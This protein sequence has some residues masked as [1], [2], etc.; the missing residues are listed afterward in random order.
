MIG[1]PFVYT[2]A[3]LMFAGFAWLGWSDSANP[4][5]WT[6][7][8]FW[9][10][11]AV[12]FLAGDQIGDFGNGL[13]V[14]ALAGVAMLG[15]GRS[16]RPTTDPEMRGQEAARRG[17]RL[18][19]AA[20]IVPAVALT[21]ALSFR[22]FPGL[23][24]TK[25]ATLVALSFG[26]LIALVAIGT[27]LRPAPVTP[28]SEGKR[29]MDAVGCA[30]QMPQMLAALG[31]LFAAAGVGQVVGQLVGPVLPH[32]LLPAIVAYCLGM[33]LLTILMG[34]AFA[35]FPVM[36]AA[37]GLPILMQQEHGIPAGVAALGMLAGFCGTLLTP[38]A[39][40]FNIV[41]AALLELR[42]RYGVIRAQARTAFVMFFVNVALMYFLA[43]PR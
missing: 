5:R 42:D 20:L 7:G 27:W 2:V 38:M 11:L 8:L 24:E 39:A 1:L 36:T 23:I 29:L 28:L 17:N 19:A 10:L 21:G 15:L 41:P 30:A 33:A 34:N 6:N 31:S 13:L 35:A 25:Q 4:K 18:F 37:I 9:G 32:G 12:S 26:V 43:F 14:V 40:N 16:G 3:G 22:Y